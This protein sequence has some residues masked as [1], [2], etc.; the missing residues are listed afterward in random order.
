MCVCV[1][2]PLKLASKGEPR[3]AY[4]S[5][6]GSFS[7]KNPASKTVTSKVTQHG[8]ARLV[9]LVFEEE[10]KKHRGSFSISHSGP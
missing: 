1:F 2:L 9:K 8:K 5:L 3:P 6:L 10:K 7:E 4:S